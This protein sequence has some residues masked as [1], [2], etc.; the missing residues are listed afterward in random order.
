MDF[1]RYFTNRELEDTLNEWITT[2]PD[3]ISIKVIGRSH[4]G[5]SIWLLII[6]N[7]ETGPD[8]EKPAVWIDANIHATEIAGTTTSMRLI[9][10]LLSGYGKD[11][12]TTCL[13]DSSVYYVV[14]RVNPDGAQLAMAEIPQF[15]RSGVRPYPWEDKDEGIHSL[16]IDQDGRI[17]LMRIPDPNGDWKISTLDSRL[18]ERRGIDEQGGQYYRLLPEGIVEDY[19]G[20]Q[21][22]IAHPHRSLDFNRNFPVEWRPEN[23]QRGAG[24]YPGSEPE[25][26]AL[27]DFIT[28]SVTITI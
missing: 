1:N 22:K 23:E 2:Y 6:T 24:P 17:L 5:Y 16:D 13:L 20:Y 11:D 10:T 12:Q 27:I 9:H 25:I 14:P 18:M 28:I 8:T 19:D 26:K 7:W 4:E 21:I 15:V 3:L